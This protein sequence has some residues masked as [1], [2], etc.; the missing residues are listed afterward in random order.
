[1]TEDE[2]DLALFM[3]IAILSKCAELWVFGDR[4]TEGMEKEISYARSKGMKARYIAEE[5]LICTK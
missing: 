2:R 4:I 5:K 3:D 1:M